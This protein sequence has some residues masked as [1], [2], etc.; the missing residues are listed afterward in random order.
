[1][2]RDKI[3]SIQFEIARRKKR[4]HLHVLFVAEEKNYWFMPCANV[5]CHFIHL[6]ACKNALDQNDF[7]TIKYI[8][9]PLNWEFNISNQKTS[10][11]NS[12]ALAHMHRA[13]SP[14]PVYMQHQSMKIVKYCKHH[15]VPQRTITTLN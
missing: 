2:M 15:I 9:Y 3:A 1:M 6:D 5:P 7:A 4:A 12:I 11:E 13:H 8:L 10:T 14:H